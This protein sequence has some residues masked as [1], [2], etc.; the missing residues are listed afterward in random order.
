MGDWRWDSIMLHKSWKPNWQI[1]NE[2]S[3]QK[4]NAKVNRGEGGLVFRGGQ[5]RAQGTRRW[6]PLPQRQ[7]GRRGYGRGYGRVWVDGVYEILDGVGNGS[8]GG[9]TGIH[10]R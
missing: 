8:G 2:E 5:D 4:E 10:K 1:R 6:C 7:A 9:G 3:T